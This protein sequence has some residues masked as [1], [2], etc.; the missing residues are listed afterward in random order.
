MIL[1]YSQLIVF[2]LHSLESCEGH[3]IVKSLGRDERRLK[4]SVSNCL[5]QRQ[6]GQNKSSKNT[7]F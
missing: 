3:E 6:I 4:R 2:C 7:M 1:T 5:Y